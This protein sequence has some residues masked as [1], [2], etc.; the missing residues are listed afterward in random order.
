[1]IWKMLAEINARES[2]EKWTYNEG[3]HGNQQAEKSRRPSVSPN[4]S[5]VCWRLGHFGNRFCFGHIQLIPTIGKAPSMTA[6][7]PPSSSSCPKCRFE[8]WRRR[9]LSALKAAIPPP[10]H[11]PQPDFS[12]L[13]SLRRRGIGRWWWCGSRGAVVP[14]WTAVPVGVRLM[15]KGHLGSEIIGRL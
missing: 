2:A 5:H 9:N 10:L 11:P 15:G 1:M 6:H 8:R 12:L 14:V 13:R 4:P 7:P 3:C